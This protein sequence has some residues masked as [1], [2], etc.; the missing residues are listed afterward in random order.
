V[1][2]A[3]QLLADLSLSSTFLATRDNPR[4]EG[5]TNSARQE[6]EPPMVDKPSQ[7]EEEYFA[8]QEFERRKKAAE[9][10][11]AVLAQEERRRLRELHHMRCPKCG[12]ELVE[13]SFREIRIDRCSACNGVWL[14]AGE[15]E[16]ITAKEPGGFLK[17]F[18]GL[19]G[20]ESKR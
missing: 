15:L 14:D 3:A 4:I 19:F 12:M 7:S 20:G 8:R 17:G 10:R 13:L 18:S 16:S 6:G 11:A 5:W 1:T 9:E 2:R